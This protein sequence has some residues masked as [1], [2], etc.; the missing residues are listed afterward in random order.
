[1]I[2]RK[3]GIA[4]TNKLMALA[5]MEMPARSMIPA[6]QDFV[7]LEDII[8]GKPSQ[9]TSNILS[10]DNN[11]CTDDLCSAVTGECTHTPNTDT[12]SDG[13]DCTMNDLCANGKCVPGKAQLCFDNNACTN[14]TCAPSGG[15]IFSPNELPCT[16][17]DLC[18]H[19]GRCQA[20]RCVPGLP[21]KC[22]DDGNACTIEYCNPKTGECL[23]IESIGECE[24]GDPC[25][26]NDMC[27]DGICIPGDPKRW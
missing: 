8:A 16:T 18:L 26:V 15:C 11:T 6:W 7:C 12:C 1:M 22:E 27:D 9:Y 2:D 23:T 5:M 14:D 21:I 25:T 3:K 20:G 17:N 13:N 10:D 19:E 24:D 4:N